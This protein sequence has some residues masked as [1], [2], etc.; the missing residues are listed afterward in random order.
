MTACTPTEVQLRRSTLAKQM[1]VT[2]RR[3]DEHVRL[4]RDLVPKEFKYYTGQRIFTARQA[5]ALIAIRR[6]FENGWIEPQV[7]DEIIKKGLPR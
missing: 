6:W 1:G 7:K 4:L 5:E 3:L 2:T